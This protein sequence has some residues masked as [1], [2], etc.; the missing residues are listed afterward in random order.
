MCSKS[1]TPSSISQAG[2]TACKI[3]VS[4]VLIHA[5]IL[6]GRGRGGGNGM[7]RRK[8]KKKSGVVFYRERTEKMRENAKYL[9]MSMITPSL[10]FFHQSAHTTLLHLRQ[11]WRKMHKIFFKRQT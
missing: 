2:E 9:N 8:K 7:R 5:I 1:I 11:K 4:S 3:K 6:G 10:F